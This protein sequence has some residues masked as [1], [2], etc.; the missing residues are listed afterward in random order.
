VVGDQCPKMRPGAAAVRPLARMRGRGEREGARG[1][2]QREKRGG[3][4][5]GGDGQRPFKR[6]GG[7]VREGGQ[8]VGG[9]HEAG[10]SRGRA[11]GTGTGSEPACA[12]GRRAPM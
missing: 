11:W 6:R 8:A 3:E 9:G 7:G 5:R 10:R 12:G 2:L 4:G 1:V